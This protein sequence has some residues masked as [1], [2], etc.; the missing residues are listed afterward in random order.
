MEDFKDKKIIITGGS[1]GI[2]LAVSQE[3]SMLGAIIIMISTDI[4]KLRLALDKLSGKNH[5]CY[6]FNLANV[7]GIEVFLNRVLSE[8]G[9]I[10]GFV[11]CAG[12]A[13]IRPL[14]QSKYN[15]MLN[16]M[17]VNFFSFVE[18]I[19]VISKKKFYNE[20]LNIVGISAIGAFLGNSTKTAYSSSKSAMNSAIRCIAKELHSKSIR[21]NA[22]A[23]GVTETAMLYDYS[24][25]FSSSDEYNSVIQRQYLGLCLPKDIADT[26]LFLL[27]D[28]SRMITGSCI[29]VD[30]GK[31]SS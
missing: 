26:V 19:R 3:L 18:I 1:S 9:P 16:V 21:I 12:V 31:L 10:D 29:S 5:V 24:E 13:P 14:S 23:P 17:N 22:V 2:G 11:H 28:K 20:S 15:F 4:V 30:G 8:I 6:D 7:E 27:S 25:K